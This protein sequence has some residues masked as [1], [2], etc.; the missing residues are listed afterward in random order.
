[1]DSVS[2]AFIIAAGG[3][4]VLFLLPFLLMATYVCLRGV[5]SYMIRDPHGYRE[6]NRLR[7]E[8]NKAA[9]LERRRRHVMTVYL[10]NEVRRKEWQEFLIDLGIGAAASLLT[11]GA[12][13]W[14]WGWRKRWREKKDKERKRN[15]IELRLQEN[16]AAMEAA[17]ERGFAEGLG[18]PIP[19]AGIG[20]GGQVTSVSQSP[21][22]TNTLCEEE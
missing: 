20:P 22:L 19:S 3:L 16:L 1:M 11:A 5:W 9:R 2:S 13:W 21:G 14:R 10:E 8:W 17:F 6:W 15:N 4:G 18:L 7:K 12:L